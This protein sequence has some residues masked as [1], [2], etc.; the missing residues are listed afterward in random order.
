M[1]IVILDDYYYMRQDAFRELC[2]SHEVRIA[3]DTT[4]LNA[5]ESD[6]AFT[7][8]LALSSSFFDF[9]LPNSF[10][11]HFPMLRGI[12]ISGG[13]HEFIDTEYCMSHGIVLTRVPRQDAH[14]A[15]EWCLMATIYLA[16]H[17]PLDDAS[18]LPSL[19]KPGIELANRRAG[20]IGLGGIGT[21]LARLLTSIGM[22]CSYWSR[23]TRSHEMEY[24]ELD[25]L[26]QTVEFVYLTFYESKTLA[27][28]FS[29][30]RLD[31][32]SDTA[33]IISGLGCKTGLASSVVDWRYAI[34]KVQKGTLAGLAMHRHPHDLQINTNGNVLL[35][36]PDSGWFTLEALTAQTR[37]WVSNIKAMVDGVPVN[38]FL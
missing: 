38:R 13:Y 5:I 3:T 25:E 37:V 31:F 34:H 28:F 10:L 27:G 23:S 29:R 16:R 20:I 14:A 19:P 33:Y 24:L 6:F 26:L 11:R 12:C 35:A 17:M 2:Q 1:R 21:E 7:D 18:L 22:R 9:S 8:I 15:A 4:T 30:R 32:L 36:R